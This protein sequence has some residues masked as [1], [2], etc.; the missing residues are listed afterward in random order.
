MAVPSTTINYPLTTISLSDASGSIATLS[1]GELTVPS[2]IPSIIVDSA[3]SAGAANQVLTSGP[4]G[5]SL[6]WADPFCPAT[7][8]PTSIEDVTNATG[9]ANQV[10]TAGVAGGS[11]VWA[12]LPS[13]ATPSLADVLAVSPA[14]VADAGQTIS[15]LASLSVLDS[16]NTATLTGTNF[17]I[18]NNSDANILSNIT[19]GS[20]V[21]QSGGDI[22][23]L[24][25]TGGLGL[26]DGPS[27]TWTELKRAQLKSGQSTFDISL[28]SLTLEGVASTVGQVITAD[29]SGAP[30][31][32][33]LPSS[34]TPS[35]ADVMAVATAGDA[36]GQALSN[37]PS[38]A[39]TA[40]AGSAVTLAAVAAN[41]HLSISTLPDT[42]GGAKDFSRSYLPMVI[43]GTLYYIPL[44]VVPS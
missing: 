39:M 32:A 14:G 44:F 38:V 26:V 11:V 6:V 41:D 16:T 10:L 7:I 42:S 19:T 12:D 15:G 33:D 5:T 2:I 29:A 25:S 43:G 22:T 30:Y 18:V 8:T 17:N 36:G 28:N 40:G 24:S 3:V 31:W 37:F 34:T 21:V 9:T 13:S 4:E 35:L 1:G 23:H 27:G 20:L